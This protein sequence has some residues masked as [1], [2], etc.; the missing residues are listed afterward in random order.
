MPKFPGTVV[1]KSHDT[2]HT[3]ECPVCH[4]IRIIASGI[5]EFSKAKEIEVLRKAGWILMPRRKCPGC[6]V[7]EKKYPI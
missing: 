2:I 5:R 3:V 4:C 6:Q 1:P 7:V